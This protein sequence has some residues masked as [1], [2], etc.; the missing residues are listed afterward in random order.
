ML[1]AVWLHLGKDR[2]KTPSGRIWRVKREI[3]R[4]EEHMGDNRQSQECVGIRYQCP[5][6][7][8]SSFLSRSS[9]LPSVAFCYLLLP[10]ATLVTNL[11]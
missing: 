11:P 5:V 8:D 3:E 4:E 2:V 10:F 9:L 7:R 6:A 1:D